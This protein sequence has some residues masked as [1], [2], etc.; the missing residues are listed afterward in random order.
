MYKYANRQGTI[1]IFKAMCFSP[2]SL[3]TLARYTS[4]GQQLGVTYLLLLGRHNREVGEKETS[5]PSDHFTLCFVS[6]VHLQ[7]EM[8]MWSQ[9][10]VSGGRGCRLGSTVHNQVSN[11]V[12]SQKTGMCF[13]KDS[14]QDPVP[15]GRSFKSLP[16]NPLKWSEAREDSKVWGNGH[17]T[18]DISVHSGDSS[19]SPKLTLSPA[20]TRFCLLQCLEV[21]ATI[22]SYGNMECFPSLVPPGWAHHPHS[23]AQ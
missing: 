23:V 22:C 16:R 2:S 3:S 8:R 5:S 15:S 13:L 17:Q 12:S 6:Y 1:L 9:G 14:G 4:I 18:S 20:P 21:S 11:R 10:G 7:R 19:L